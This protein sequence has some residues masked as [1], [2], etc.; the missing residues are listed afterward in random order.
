MPATDLIHGNADHSEQR[1]IG[2]SSLLAR[3]AVREERDNKCFR[4]GRENSNNVNC[5]R[6]SLRGSCWAG[7]LVFVREEIWALQVSVQ[8]S[9]GS[10]VTS[11]RVAGSLIHECGSDSSGRSVCD[12]VVR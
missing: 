3:E 2:I 4:G 10:G 6:W 1:I 5:K 11:L 8:C 7:G 9:W 12:A